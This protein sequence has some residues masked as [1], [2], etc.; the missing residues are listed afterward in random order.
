MNDMR[1]LLIAGLLIA[2][3]IAPAGCDLF[4]PREAEKPGEETNEYPWVVPNRP[5]DVFV[6]L[7]SGLASPLNSNYERS[8]DGSFT[9]IPSADAEAVYP[10]AFS[11]WT[12]AVELDVLDR[13]KTLYLGARTVQFGDENLNFTVENE[14]VGHATYEG[15]YSITLNVGDA[16]PPAVYSGIARFTIVQ[17]TQG[18]VMTIWEDIQPIGTSQTSG[19]LRG[20][21]RQ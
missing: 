6:N 18:W 19:F 8:L 1:K 21:L 20:A 17:G 4:D 9:F 16:S 3:A 10:G 11:D 15:P 13:I 12:K 14:Q 7:T 2:G 5:K